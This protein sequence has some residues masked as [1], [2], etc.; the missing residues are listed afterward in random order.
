M[1]SKMRNIYDSYRGEF[2]AYQKFENGC[3]NSLHTE[4][5]I[6]DILGDKIK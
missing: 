1:W 3:R 4:L 6:L 2:T 5:V